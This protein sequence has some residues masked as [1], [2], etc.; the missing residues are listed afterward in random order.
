MISI[1]H[2]FPGFIEKEYVCLFFQSKLEN[3][4]IDN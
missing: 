3:V 2:I 1:S 4:S